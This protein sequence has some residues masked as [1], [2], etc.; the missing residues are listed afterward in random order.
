MEFTKDDYVV[1]GNLEVI[2]AYTNGVITSWD[3]SK[4]TIKHSWVII[5]GTTWSSVVNR[6]SIL[7]I[8]INIKVKEG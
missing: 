2:L 3:V 1:E 8:N 6:D 7:G 4:V 5:E